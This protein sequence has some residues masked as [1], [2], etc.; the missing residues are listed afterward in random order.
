[1]IH[2][3]YS[4]K[5]TRVNGSEYQFQ[6]DPKNLHD[7]YIRYEMCY[8]TTP[9]E[10]ATEDLLRMTGIELANMV[11]CLDNKMPG[12][13]LTFFFINHGE[14]ATGAHI[15][16]L[17]FYART[18][19]RLNQ[20]NLEMTVPF[21]TEYSELSR[22]QFGDLSATKTKKFYRDTLTDGWHQDAIPHHYGLANLTLDYYAER[23]FREVT[24]P[25]NGIIRALKMRE[26][27]R[28]YAAY[29]FGRY[30]QFQPM[31]GELHHE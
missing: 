26:Y 6:A 19:D 12:K 13:G 16:N 25:E 1:M 8:M 30:F 15:Y 28:V 5:I 17:C 24:Y 9:I 22:R 10:Q 29:L 7:L 21:H 18:A 27:A 4:D 31:K 3:F 23:T 11:G 14:I 20:E 2:E